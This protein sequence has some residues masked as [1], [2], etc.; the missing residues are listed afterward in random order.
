MTT[1]H[2]TDRP[3]E[4]AICSLCEHDLFA[5]ENGHVYCSNDD[6]RAHVEPHPTG[7]KLNAPEWAQR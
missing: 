3:N 4:G 6:C 2:R 7:Q 1:F 5:A